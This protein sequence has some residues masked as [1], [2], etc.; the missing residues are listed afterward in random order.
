MIVAYFAESR[1]KEN[2]PFL[3]RISM[4]ADSRFPICTLISPEPYFYDRQEVKD[5]E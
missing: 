1:V 5:D 4:M 2:S 3:V